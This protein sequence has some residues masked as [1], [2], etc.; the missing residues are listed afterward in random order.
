MAK[1]MTWEEYTEQ[2]IIHA[3][4]EKEKCLKKYQENLKIVNNLQTY[5]T[6]L[7]MSL[8]VTEGILNV[9]SR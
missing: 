8:K 5:I 2:M 6:A 7:E 1:P 9:K 3:R 4:I